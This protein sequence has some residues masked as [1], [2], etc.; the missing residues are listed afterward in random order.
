MLKKFTEVLK[1]ALQKD[2]PGEK[3]QKKM[4]PIVLNNIKFEF[5]N[6]PRESAVTILFYE[7][8]KKIKIIFIKRNEDGKA[9]SGQVAFPGG[10]YE[11]EDKNL[12]TTALRETFEEIGI[13]QSK[14]KIIGQ[15]TPLYIPISNFRVTPFVAYLENV[16][17]YKISESEVQ[18]IITAE[19]T[20]FFNDK[21]LGTRELKRNEIIISAPFFGVQNDIVW[22]ATAM[23]TSELYEVLKNIDLNFL[24]S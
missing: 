18:K 16:P 24:Q 13:E 1:A 11:L 7:E 2:L 19:I 3:A 23:I 5:K 15:L 21:N 9:H 4:A 17:T 20:E 10:K 14:I 22:G 6:E 8:D 12:K